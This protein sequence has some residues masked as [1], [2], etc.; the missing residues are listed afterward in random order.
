MLEKLYE[1]KRQAI[2]FRIEALRRESEELEKKAM[3]SKKRKGIGKWLGFTFQSSSSKTREFRSFVRDFKKALKENTEKDFDLVNFSKGH[4]YCT[5]FLRSKEN[6]KMVY[7]SISD[8]RFFPDE[9]FNNVLIRTAEN[10][11]DYTGG[12]NNYCRFYEIREKALR[13]INWG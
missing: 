13:L 3:E 8:V 12:S 7:F 4:F 2:N 1:E 6:G 5:G 11:K 9:W 10:E